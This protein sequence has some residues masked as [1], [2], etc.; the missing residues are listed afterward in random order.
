MLHRRF[1]SSLIL[2]AIGLPAV[3]AASP[4]RSNN[5]AAARAARPAQAE[6]PRRMP[7][8]IEALPLPVPVRATPAEPTPTPKLKPRPE[9]RPGLKP[10]VAS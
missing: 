10:R 6:P 9:K 3:A 5:R 4:A 8:R 2:V 7:S 1:V